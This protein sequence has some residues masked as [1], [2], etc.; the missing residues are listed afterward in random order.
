MIEW[1]DHS[2]PWE[3]ELY[4]PL[5]GNTM[6]ELGNKRKGDIV[7]KE[8]FQSIGFEHT[9]VDLNGLDG[10]LRLDLSKPLGLGTFDMVTNLGTSEHVS[11]KNYEGQ[12]QCWRNMLE[13]MSVGSVL[14]SITPQPGTW[15]DHGTWYPRL[16][17]FTELADL[18]SMELERAE[19][20]DWIAGHPNRRL[21]TARLVRRE[22]VPFKMPGRGCMFINR[23]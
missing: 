18:N 21:V 8:F 14:I 13:A 5:V 2:R 11:E 22:L 6:L 16:G 19:E 1:P 12:V 10:A 23:R 15:L 17:F 20:R 3:W 4:Q 9:S 7:Y